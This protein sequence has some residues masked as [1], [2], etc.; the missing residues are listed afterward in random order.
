MSFGYFI[1]YIF[2]CLQTEISAFIVLKNE[3]TGGEDLILLARGLILLVLSDKT[4]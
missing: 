2:K 4:F 3:V 1:C